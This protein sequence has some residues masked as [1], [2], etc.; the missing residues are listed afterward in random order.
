MGPLHRAVYETGRDTAVCRTVLATA[1]SGIPSHGSIF[2]P[3]LMFRPS[4]AAGKA[5]SET[6]ASLTPKSRKTL[7]HQLSSAPEGWA[8][9]RGTCDGDSPPAPWGCRGCHQHVTQ[10][11]V[12]SLSPSRFLALCTPAP[13]IFIFQQTTL[14]Q[15]NKFLTMTFGCSEIFFAYKQNRTFVFFFSPQTTLISVVLLDLGVPT[16][17]TALQSSLDIAGKIGPLTSQACGHP[18]RRTLGAKRL[19]STL[20]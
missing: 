9:S 16:G 19:F 10:P 13:K 7:L 4:P 11:R 2:T 5:G 15:G 18:L 6:A 14:Q 12:Y 1:E 20:Q 3:A 17:S 8:V